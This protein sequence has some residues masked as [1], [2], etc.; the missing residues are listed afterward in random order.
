M[1]FATSGCV[2]PLDNNVRGFDPDAVYLPIRLYIPGVTPATKVSP[3]DI[4][5]LTGNTESQIHCVQ[6]WM[7]TNGGDVNES[8]VAYAE[9]E[10]LYSQTGNLPNGSGYYAQSFWEN[11]YTYKLFMRIPR[12]VLK[13]S[14][15]KF[16]FYVL[17]NAKSIGTTTLQ[18]MTRKELQESKFGVVME[19]G[20]I[21]YDYFGTT[22]SSNPVISPVIKVGENGLP[23]S[24]FYANVDLS[25]LKEDKEVFNIEDVYDQLPIVQLERAISRIRFSFAKPTGLTGVQIIKVEIDGNQIPTST[26]VFPRE[27]GEFPTDYVYPTSTGYVPILQGT[28]LLSDTQI[29]SCDNPEDLKSTSP[30]VFSRD[31]PDGK[32]YK[33]KAPLGETTATTMN[34]QEYND[35]L[36]DYTTSKYVYLRESGEPISGKIYYKLSASQENPSV[37]SFS[38]KPD[39]TNPLGYFN[40]T[41][42]H[43]NHS[44]TVYGYFKGD[45]LY[46]NP[47][48]KDWDDV[49]LY[50][51][52]QKGYASISVSDAFQSLFGYGWTTS[53]LNSWYKPYLSQNTEWYF[54]WEDGNG[55]DWVNSQVV[56]APGVNDEDVPLYANRIE[57]ITRDFDTPLR[58]KLSNHNKFY[59]VT[60]DL[61]DTQQRYVSHY[62]ADGAE[63]PSGNRTTFF[64]VVPRISDNSQFNAE[65]G[66]KTEA[67]LVTNPGYGQGNEKIPFNTSIFPGS[68][69]NT[70]IYFRCVKE[71]TF[72]SYYSTL[73]SNVKAYTQ[74]GQ[75]VNL[76]T[77]Q[78]IV[79]NP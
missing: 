7:F 8:A 16:D 5:G 59:I 38:M 76:Q 36:D 75:E 64:Y 23:I 63:I 70:E 58:I 50:K 6:V 30:K 10:T 2:E 55:D 34:A 68:E 26:Y 71:A 24:G 45:G 73:P 21:K 32:S 28:P 79:V 42:F 46:I 35:L 17:A 40:T 69:E 27:N 49:A 13:G 61:D 56:I 12:S 47:V 52:Q 41:N 31:V 20:A 3:S 29:A 54:R 67:Y 18:A 14:N 11:T 37:V 25:F 65:E 48:V 77:G 66:D 22:T 1:V 62:G 51:Y 9:A 60:Y 57:L 53:H 33:G 78:I 72:Q 4:K 44:W 74:L 43:R 39:D 15:L 19:N